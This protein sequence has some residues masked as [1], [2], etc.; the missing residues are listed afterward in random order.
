MH[1][2]ANGASSAQKRANW[3][4][5]G[6]FLASQGINLTDATTE[7]VMAQD[8]AAVEKFLQQLHLCAPG[9]CGGFRGERAVPRT[10][11]ALMRRRR[12]L[13]RAAVR[14]ARGQAWLAAG[15]WASWAKR[16]VCRSQ[17]RAANNMRTLPHKQADCRFVTRAPSCGEVSQVPPAAAALNTPRAAAAAT[18]GFAQPFASPPYD[19]A[20]AFLFGA[21]APTH[22]GAHAPPPP[23][24]HR[25]TQHGKAAS[26]L[27]SSVVPT[28]QYTPDAAAAAAS[29]GAPAAPAVPDPAAPMHAQVR[30]RVAQMGAQ[31]RHATMQRVLQQRATFVNVRGRT[32]ALRA[33]VPALSR[34][35]N[36]HEA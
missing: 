21:A 20:P 33:S 25:N 36:G 14:T 18:N 12:A 17:P 28:M 15:L 8:Q 4:L 3:D 29:A 32:A 30:Q 10:L 35:P 5:I 9:K 24:G 7:A 34:E 22:M 1:S 23:V 2:Y 6:R 13:M 27:G 26:M 31:E 11:G 19:S 16:S